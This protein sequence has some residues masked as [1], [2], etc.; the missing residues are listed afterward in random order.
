MD[1]YIYVEVKKS[2]NFYVLIMVIVGV[3]SLYLKIINEM[4]STYLTK[5]INMCRFA[6]FADVSAARS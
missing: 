2:L 6:L 3:L 1:D 4:G 5:A